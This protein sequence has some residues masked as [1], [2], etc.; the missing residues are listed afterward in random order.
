MNSTTKQSIP[1]VETAAENLG[2]YTL[3]DNMLALFTLS[4]PPALAT[5]VAVHS[6][7]EAHSINTLKINIGLATSVSDGLKQHVA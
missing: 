1:F 6:K 3:L 5:S 7:V 4:S 2:V